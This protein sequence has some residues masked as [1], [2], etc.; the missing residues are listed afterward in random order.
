MP[1]KLTRPQPRVGQLH[2]SRKGAPHI[3]FIYRKLEADILEAYDSFI[4]NY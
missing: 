4:Q 2:A 1:Q 3:D